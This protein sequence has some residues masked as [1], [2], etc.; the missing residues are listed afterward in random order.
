MAVTLPMLWAVALTGSARGLATNCTQ[1]G[2]IVT[3]TYQYTG[4]EQ[5]FAVPSNVSSVNVSATG[6]A[7]GGTLGGFGATVSGTVA[8]PAGST[9]YVEVGGMG[10]DTSGGFDGGGSPGSDSVSTPAGAGGGG[11][12][13]VRTVSCADPCVDAGSLTSR[14]IVAAG[15]G[16]IGGLRLGAG[17]AAAGGAA[18]SNGTDGGSSGV[19]G[20]GGGGGAGSTGGTAGLAGSP[21]AGGT[22]GAAGTPG[23][24]GDG[25]AGGPGAGSTTT[26]GGGGGG[27][28]G[29][30][31][32]GSGAFAVGS[33]GGGGG[34]GGG[35]SLV[36][37]GGATGVAADRADGS[38]TITY[39]VPDT[40]APTISITTPSANAGYALGASVTAAYSC[41]D[42]T[43]G[44][45]LASCAGPVASGSPIDTSSLGVHTFT[46]TATDQAGN[47]ASQT[48]GYIVFGQPSASIQ[49]PRS[50]GTYT[51][52]QIVTTRFA[53]AE[54]QSG[55]GLAQ[56]EDSNDVAATPG[57]ATT[58]SA[59]SQLDTST[60]GQHVYTVV[61][62]SA[63]GLQ[64]RE[65]IR[66][67]V[68]AA[69]TVSIIS[70]VANHVYGSAKQVPHA[71]YHCT[72]GA[73]GPGIKSCTARERRQSVSASKTTIPA[74]L[75]VTATS[76]DGLTTTKTVSWWVG[77]HVT[78]AAP[79]YL[80]TDHGAIPVTRLRSVHAAGQP[81]CHKL[82]ALQNC[83]QTPAGFTATILL[84]PSR[85]SL[86]VSW[87]HQVKIGTP[88]ARTTIDLVAT[89]GSGQARQLYT[90]TNA[91][92]SKITI[93]RLKAGQ[94][95][96]ATIT[97]TFTGDALTRSKG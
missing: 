19:Q 90:L 39:T 13:D 34:G 49:T 78:S 56:C 7:G 86:L 55:P 60:L 44:S 41:A 67:T 36:P 58:K 42:E 46:V 73:F 57:L 87:S 68:A 38:V 94:T 51:R 45:G 48:I 96:T 20:G 24:T 85:E 91:W 83:T 28:I 92:P 75:S 8:V 93:N 1:T 12:S 64:G 23:T 6:A 43:G 47:H 61:A 53:C 11:A 4:S 84:E 63:D 15:G 74:T 25:G 3:C 72:D 29:G 71:K 32:G 88:N 97:A 59:T 54:G 9:L 52:D 14:L 40:T 82:G 35:S 5:T 31:G 62:T 22:A 33:V 89:A 95:G 80:D 81:V 10:S 69:P 37:S 66:Y 30:G 2:R 16:G 27:D 76:K 77:E 79:Y 50:G 17:A 21:G 18:G 70:P 26:G 65:Q